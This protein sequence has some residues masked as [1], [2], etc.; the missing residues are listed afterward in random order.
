MDTN[1]RRQQMLKKWES[2]RRSYP[3]YNLC[4]DKQFIEPYILSR[5]THGH[6]IDFLVVN[7]QG[8]NWYDKPDVLMDFELFSQFGMVRPGDTVFDCGAHQGYYALLLSRMVGPS[9]KVYSFEPFP[10]LTDVIDCNIELNQ[11]SNVKLYRVGLSNIKTKIQGSLNEENVGITRHQDAVDIEL[12]TLDNYAHLKPNF[13]KLDVEGAE[14]NA[15]QGAAKLLQQTPNLYI[16]VHVQYLPHFNR[17]AMEIFDFVR[18]KDYNMIICYPDQPLMFY[19]CEFPIER[20]CALYCVRKDVEFYKRTTLQTPT[21]LQ[22]MTALIKKQRDQ[23]MQVAARLAHAREE[24]SKAAA[25][26]APTTASVSTVV[27]TERPSLRRR[28]AKLWR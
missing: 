19:N 4:H 10:I 23:S 3:A 25:V 16:E 9:G 14:V 13:V 6:E 11:A 17:R 15:L 8:Q 1:T 21:A 2:V 12:D 5:K 18:A 24:A 28:L 26:A 7:E 20:S 27:A 22:A